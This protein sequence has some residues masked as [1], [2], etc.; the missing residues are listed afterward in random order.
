MT[1][2]SE[3]FYTRRSRVARPDPDPGIDSSIDRNYNRRYHNHR[4]D[5]DGC[6]HLRLS[7]HVRHSTSRSY[8]LSERAS[9][10]S[11]QGS[12]RFVSING[13]NAESVS[14][15]NRQSLHSNERLPEAVLLAR[16]RLLERLRGVSVSANRLMQGT[17]EVK[18]LQGCQVG[19]PLSPTKPLKQKK[20][21]KSL[22]V[23]RRRP[24][25]VYRWRYSGAKRWMGEG[26]QGIAV[27]VWRGSGTKMCLQGWCVDI[28]FT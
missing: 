22:L 3:L 24:W 1:S 15:S 4:H 2:A 11:D 26:N 8:S 13:V 14:S 20:R 17:R 7:P 10:Q 6:Q 19:V 18:F 16:A 27:Y 12:S 9:M 5:L 28:G 23:L 25:T 21:T